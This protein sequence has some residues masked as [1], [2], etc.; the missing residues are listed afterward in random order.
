MTKPT[1]GNSWVI[2]ERTE[3]IVDANEAGLRFPKLAAQIQQG[4]DEGLHRGG[5]VFVS[6]RDELRADWA[7]GEN[8][9]GQ[10]V[11]RDMLFPWLSCTKPLAA[12]ALGQLFEQGLLEWHDPV[13]KFLPEFAVHGKEAVTLWHLLTH[14]AGLRTFGRGS[15]A[16]TWDET[17][18]AICALPME[19]DWLLGQRAGYHVGSSWFLLAEIVCRLSGKTYSDY[20]RENIF[21]PLGMTDFWC[22]M[23]PDVAEEYVRTNRIASMWVTERGQSG[24]QPW[25]SIEHLQWCS[26]GAGGWGPIAQLGRFQEALRNGGDGILQPETIRQLSFRHRV[27]LRD[28]T[29]QHTMD[30]GLGFIVNS[31]KYGVQSVPYGYGLHASPETFGHGGYQSSTGFVDPVHGLAVAMVMNG[32]PGEARNQKRYRGLCTALYEDLGLGR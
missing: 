9:P 14:T 20:L 23:P 28:E 7:F 32:T 2:N 18:A 22:G 8:E 13:V 21:Q 4:I 10:P 15:P 24:K 25:G 26:P 5:Q 19:P 29:F 11:T 6:L 30:W 31:A 12:V 17:I 1:D 16:Q 3:V 27:G